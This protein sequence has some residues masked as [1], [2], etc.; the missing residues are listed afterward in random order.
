MKR[1]SYADRLVMMILRAYQ[2]AISPLL[3]HACRYLPTCSEYAT[4]AVARH[5]IL[6]GGWL[7]GRRLLRCH[8]WAGSGFDPVPPVLGEN[9][10]FA[11]GHDGTDCGKT[12]G[13]KHRALA[14]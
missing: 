12:H 13:W 11:S 7:S 10:G 2:R 14:R 6:R 8:A 4:E 5:G 3:P 1:T 9:L